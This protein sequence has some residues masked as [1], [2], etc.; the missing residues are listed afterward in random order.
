MTKTNISTEMMDTL[1]KLSA[2]VG[3]TK[4][5]RFC[6]NTWCEFNDLK[7]DSPIEQII[8][9]HL[10]YLGELNDLGSFD[11]IHILDNCWQ[12]GLNII[13][14]Y[15]IGKY[16]CDF[17]VSYA[18]KPNMRGVQLI[19]RELLVECDS[20]KFH[21]RTEPERRYEKERDRYLISSGHKVFHY[22]GSEIVKNPMKICTEILSFLTDIPEDV[23]DLDSNFG[24]FGDI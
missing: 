9:A 12:F 1:K 15:K 17:Y 5:N 7:I 11:E 4:I 20:Q 18:S 19:K 14:Q 24:E 13:P 21:E 2:E 22:T 6:A 23:F 10:K 8:Y 16:R 3:K